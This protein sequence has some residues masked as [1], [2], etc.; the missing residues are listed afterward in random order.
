MK[1]DFFLKKKIKNHQKKKKKKKKK[2]KKT[3]TPAPSGGGG[4]GAGPG[5]WQLDWAVATALPNSQAELLKNYDSLEQI[6]S[7]CNERYG[8]LRLFLRPFFF[9]FLAIF[10]FFFFLFFFFLS[11]APS[12]FP[13]PP[14]AWRKDG[15]HGTHA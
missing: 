15:R 7:Y 14:R 13:L 12:I 1:I 9:I 5:G 2:N 4:A 10:F 8:T 6:A 11:C 3:K